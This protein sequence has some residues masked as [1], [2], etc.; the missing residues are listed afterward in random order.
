ML[1]IKKAS[2]RIASKA[3]E[4]SLFI[5]RYSNRATSHAWSAEYQIHNR[6]NMDF[7][8]LWQK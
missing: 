6:C 8:T 4:I 1:Y 3:Q 5:K 7:F 2:E